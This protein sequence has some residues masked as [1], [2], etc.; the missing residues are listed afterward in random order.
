M[1]LELLRALKVEVED[2]IF[3][4][5][6]DLSVLFGDPLLLECLLRVRHEVSHR[7]EARE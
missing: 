5:L 3:E 7:N 4:K 1:V 2:A 6:D